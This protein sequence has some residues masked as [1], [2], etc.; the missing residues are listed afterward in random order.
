MEIMSVYHLPRCPYLSFSNASATV[1]THY[2]YVTGGHHGNKSPPT[3]PKPSP[4][5][6]TERSDYSRQHIIQKASW[7]GT[8]SNKWPGAKCFMLGTESK[9]HKH[10]AQFVKL[11]FLLYLFLQKGFV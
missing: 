10:T 11:C 2:Y 7:D 3:P 5:L 1:G 4:Q 8:A 9:E 6:D